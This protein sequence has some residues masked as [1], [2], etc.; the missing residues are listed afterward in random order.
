VIDY[1]SIDSVKNQ[2]SR[3]SCYSCLLGQWGLDTPCTHPE[4]RYQK[5]GVVYSQ[6]RRNILVRYGEDLRSLHMQ[7]GDE[8]VLEEWSRMPVVADDERKLLQDLGMERKV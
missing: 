4:P 1:T 3:S 5:I 2:P 6:G 7:R 8:L